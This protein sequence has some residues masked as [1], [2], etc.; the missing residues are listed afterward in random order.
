MSEIIWNLEAFRNALGDIVSDDDKVYR[1]ISQVKSLE[2]K[3]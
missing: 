3:K 2:D 1:V